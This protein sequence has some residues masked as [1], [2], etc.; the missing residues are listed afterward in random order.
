MESDTVAL[1]CSNQCCKSVKI[2]LYSE[3]CL[4]M[5]FT[6]SSWALLSLVIEKVVSNKNGGHFYEKLNFC[7]AYLKIYI[8]LISPL[9][10]FLL[11][12]CTFIRLQL[13]K[14]SIFSK[15]SLSMFKVIDDIL[16]N[17]VC[18]KPIRI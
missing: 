4:L 13:Q 14:L 10:V 9:N 18:T 5:S 16:H 15:S 11:I 17:P 7:Y 1:D 12:F 6:H 2:F 8:D 3:Q